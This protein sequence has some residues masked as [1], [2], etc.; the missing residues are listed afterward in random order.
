MYICVKRIQRDLVVSL[1]DVRNE[2]RANVSRRTDATAGF[3]N[4]LT[5][6]ATEVVW[7]IICEKV[8]T[9]DE[10]RETATSRL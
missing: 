7:P 10:W 4:E 1:E 9:T 6:V 8:V 3:S 2:A 5:R